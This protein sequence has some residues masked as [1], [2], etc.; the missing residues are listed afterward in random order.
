[1]NYKN[2]YIVC[3]FQEMRDTLHNELEEHYDELGAFA[4]V[5]AALLVIAKQTANFETE[6]AEEFDKMEADIEAERWE[7]ERIERQRKRESELATFTFDA[8]P[9]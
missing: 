6:D 4:N 8:L 9:D 1:M 2:E 3:Q 5:I 7:L